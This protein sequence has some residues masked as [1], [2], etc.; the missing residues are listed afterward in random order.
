MVTI[1]AYLDRILEDFEEYL[2]AN[3]CL[4]KLKEVHFDAGRVPD[5][6][7][8]HIQQLYLLRYAYAYA[9]EYKTIYQK[10]VKQLNPNSSLNVMSIG[11]GNMID[12]WA[13]AQNMSEDTV[14]N[15]QGY[16]C[17]DWS[18]KVQKREQ[19]H[20]RL[21]LGDAM[22]AI[23]EME[24]FTSDVIILPKSISEFS[25]SA[26][27]RLC[28]NLR[29]KPIEPQVFYLVVSLRSDAHSRTLDMGKTQKIYDAIL[30]A[31]YSSNQKKDC[32]FYLKYNDKKIREL[33]SCFQH[34]AAVVDLLPVLYTKCIKYKKNGK[35]CYDSCVQRLNRWP[36][37]RCKD[38]Q[39][40]FFKFER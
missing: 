39:W 4:C 38:L 16:D 5:Y 10:I 18:Y 33:D 17:I 8:I 29:R 23:D 15:Y 22:D 12:Y 11:C 25:S 6:S 20:V 9:F 32:Y 7:D 40:Q 19:D 30:D 35:N 3:V 37:L 27:D 14:I 31:G 26:I 28:V 21:I 1:N 36:M 34:P 2:K 13:L 24:K